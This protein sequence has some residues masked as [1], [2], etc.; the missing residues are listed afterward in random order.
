[1]L[2]T[3]LRQISDKRITILIANVY[4]LLS[5]GWLKRALSILLQNLI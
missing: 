4:L 5:M 1:M 3:Y 2:L